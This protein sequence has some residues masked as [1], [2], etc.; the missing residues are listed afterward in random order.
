MSQLCSI[1]VYQTICACVTKREFLFST[2]THTHTE[3]SSDLLKRANEI[4]KKLKRTPKIIGESSSCP[5][6]K[7]L[8]SAYRLMCN[9]LRCL[10][11]IAFI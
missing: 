9:C 1:G 5:V 7:G 2:H 6:S 11:C 8:Y 4:Q 3:A 10:T